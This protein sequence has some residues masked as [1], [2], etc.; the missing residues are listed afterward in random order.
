MK[1]QTIKDR[2]E[3]HFNKLSK[4]QQKVA[5]FV[6]KN[7]TFIG[8]HSA[9]E[10]GEKAGISET[11]V[12]RFCY[13][14]G[15]E[16]YSQLQKEI[17][18]FVF[19]HT[20]ESTLG[21]YVSSKKELFNDQCL[22]EK[23]MNKDSSKIIRIA[24]QID[25]KLFNEATH[26]LHEAKH[27]YIVGA[28]ASEFGAQWLHFT[29]N[30][31]RPNVRLIQTQTAELIRTLQEIDEQAVVIVISLHRYFKE[32]IQIAKALHERGITILAVTDSKLAPINNYC[33]YTFILEQP[34][35]STIDLMPS[36]ISFLN[37][38]VTGMMTFDPVYY[39]NQRV[40]YDDFQ[41]SFISE[42]WS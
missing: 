35:L 15:L 6:L 36:L 20:S 9:A 39:N 32:P 41:Y 2:I 4:A 16:G 37:I 13:A 18:L 38:L 19:N 29:M 11:T 24:K 1:E 28:G 17:T 25:K 12:I 23:G 42:R 34:E 14:I 3:L 5:N 40:K 22:V 21:N 31:L 7:P 8:V 33:S 30:I 10:V 27:I 26:T